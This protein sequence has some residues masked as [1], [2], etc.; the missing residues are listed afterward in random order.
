LL[1]TLCVRLHQRV[2]KIEFAE[3]TSR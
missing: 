2:N 1:G 3:G